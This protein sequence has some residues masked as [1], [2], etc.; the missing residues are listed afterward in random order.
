MQFGD[1]VARTST[2]GSTTVGS[3]MFEHASSHLAAIR[4]RK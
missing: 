2:A 3:N 1:S 4:S